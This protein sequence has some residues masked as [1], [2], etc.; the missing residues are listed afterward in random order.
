MVLITYHDVRPYGIQTHLG[1]G[2]Q[3]DDMAHIALRP[4]PQV[5]FKPIEQKDLHQ[6]LPR[7]TSGIPS[8]DL[9]P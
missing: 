1:F 6:F 8:G 2:L 4:R 3:P 9:L 7:F 5:T